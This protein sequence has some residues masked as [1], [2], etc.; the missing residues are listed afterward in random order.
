[1]SQDREVFELTI[2][3]E[4]PDIDLMGH[5]NNVVYLRWVQEAATAHWT[6]GATPEDQARV[7]WVV[8]RHEIDYL[9]PARLGDTI[10]ARTWVGPASRI[11][12]ERHVELLR[13]SD[14]AVLARARSLWCPIDSQTMKPMV[15]SQEVRERFSIAE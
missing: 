1:M 2:A 6:A 11:R 13:A 7:L 14:R 10:A 12:F 15:V 8:V 9:R 5:V 4:P 3:V